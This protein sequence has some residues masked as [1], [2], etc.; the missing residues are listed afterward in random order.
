MYVFRRTKNHYSLFHPYR[1]HRDTNFSTNKSYLRCW[2][3]CAKCES[4]GMNQEKNRRIT[5]FFRFFTWNSFMCRPVENISEFLF[6]KYFLLENYFFTL[7]WDGKHFLIE[8]E[9]FQKQKNFFDL[10]LNKT[11]PTTMDIKPLKIYLNFL[12]DLMKINFNNLCIIFKE[13]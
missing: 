6:S 5:P 10:S 7:T 11:H 1:S 9:K 13:D 8:G 3:K 4:V 12:N 2:L